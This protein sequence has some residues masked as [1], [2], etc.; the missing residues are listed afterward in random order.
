MQSP[1][2]QFKKMNKRLFM[3]IQAKTAAY[4]IGRTEAFTIVNGKALD[5][6]L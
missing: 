2:N 5:R 6:C 1:E 3:L 4:V